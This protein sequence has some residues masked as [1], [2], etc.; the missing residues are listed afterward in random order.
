MKTYN[1]WND[2]IHYM[3]GKCITL[4]AVSLRQTICTITTH[5][6]AVCSAMSIWCPMIKWFP[7]RCS[8]QPDGHITT[9]SSANGLTNRIRL[10][11]PCSFIYLSPVAASIKDLSEKADRGGL[12][13]LT[14]LIHSLSPDA[15]ETLWSQERW[16]MKSWVHTCTHQHYNCPPTKW[17]MLFSEK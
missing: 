13:S 6:P 7:V 3:K 10:I 2:Q 11:V 5:V 14:R 17:L 9:P 8:R 1:H 4:V 15:S 16:K 12:F